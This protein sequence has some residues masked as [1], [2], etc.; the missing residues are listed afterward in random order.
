MSRKRYLLQ[1]KKL[2]RELRC[3]RDVRVIFIFGIPGSGKTSFLETF[4]EK[5][6][7]QSVFLDIKD[8]DND[9]NVFMQRFSKIYGTLHRKDKYYI[10]MDNFQRVYRNRDVISYMRK[11][12]KIENFIFLISSREEFDVE[13]NFHFVKY[14]K[15]TEKDLWFEKEEVKKFYWA[16]YKRKIN[17]EHLDLIYE[18]SKGWP[19]ITDILLDVYYKK[20]IK[21]VITYHS[22]NSIGEYL[23]R[24]VIPLIPERFR[25]KIGILGLLPTGFSLSDVKDFLNK[26]DYRTLWTILNS[27]SSSIYFISYD[28]LGRWNVHSLFISF[29]R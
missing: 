2:L 4:H 23:K 24:E 27:L 25:K 7:K 18:L 15:I 12:F 26:E 17:E 29:L 28:G 22:K 11:L 1:K 21:S 14:R 6:K 5:L 16:K 20:G 3:L 9:L 19:I 10:L 13:E 8:E